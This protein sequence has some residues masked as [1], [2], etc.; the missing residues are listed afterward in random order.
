MGLPFFVDK[1]SGTTSIATPPVRQLRD[2]D[3]MWVFRSGSTTAPTVPSGWHLAPGGS[4][5]TCF[6]SLYYRWVDDLSAT[7]GTWT[8]ASLIIWATYRGVLGL[9]G[10]AAS[11]ATGT[12]VSIPAITM[13]QGAGSL[14]LVVGAAGHRTATALSAPTGMTVRA[15]Q[16]SAPIGAIWDTNGGVT[17]WSAQNSSAGAASSGHESI[18]IE[19]LGGSSTMDPFLKGTGFVL[20]NSNKTVTKTSGASA[21]AGL[22]GLPRAGVGKLIYRIDATHTD[23]SDMSPGLASSQAMALN[24]YTDYFS[25]GNSGNIFL[26]GSLVTTI[27][28]WEDGPNTVY[29]Y[30]DFDNAL[31]WG[32]VVGKNGW[33]GSG[34][35]NPATLTGGISLGTVPAFPCPAYANDQTDIGTLVWD[36]NATGNPSTTGTPWDTFSVATNI[37]IPQGALAFTGRQGKLDRGLTVPK[38]SLAIV[39]YVASLKTSTNRLIP[40]GSLALSGQALKMTQAFTLKPGQGSIATT[41]RAL[42][43]GLNYKLGS[44]AVLALTGYAPGRFVGLSRQLVAGSLSLTGRQAK[45]DMNLALKVK[46]LGISG[47]PM[48]LTG[49]DAIALHQGSLA[50]T[51]YPLSLHMNLGLKTGSLGLSGKTASLG[52]TII[53]GTASLGISGKKASLNNNL[54]L[55]VG[56]LAISGY[57]ASRGG[58]GAISPGTGNLSLVGYAPKVTIPI[59]LVLGVGIVGITG[60]QAKLDS[61]VKL[62]SGQIAVT[63]RQGK[64]DNGL[65]LKKGSLG[66]QGYAPKLSFGRVITPGVGTLGISSVR[67]KLADNFGL[68]TGHLSIQGQ[69]PTV[70]GQGG[71]QLQTGHIGIQGYAPTVTQTFIYKPANQNLAIQGYAPKVSIGTNIVIPTGHLSS[72][73]QSDHTDTNIHE[74]TAHLQI[75]GQPVTRIQDAKKVP[76]TRPLV[77]TGYPMKMNMGMHIPVCQL[78][79]TG[80]FLQRGGDFTIE[81]STGALV[82]TTYAPT[83]SIVATGRHPDPDYIGYCTPHTFEGD[84]YVS[85][86]TANIDGSAQI[87]HTRRRA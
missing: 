49:V 17:S 60:R 76:A 34:T 14:S 3:L 46:N 51:G 54:R 59:R 57:P 40:V 24:N 20:S 85:M 64:V 58:T 33:N 87:A 6:G 44:P 86:Q 56:V 84:V 61:N 15:T 16:G 43:L 48:T 63:G 38:A 4:G 55:G 25:W 73:G 69:P 68:K 12:S 77:I 27:D 22:M 35:A 2:I 65:A 62:L 81:T 45:T 28:I 67:G 79:I 66:V 39:G 36:G 18:T 32:L 50:I 42:S 7:S 11:N 82:L 29:L 71:I 5:N 31:F 19:L 80:R 83:I 47:Y 13:I 37:T 74:Q 53:P 78:G 8:S 23:L 10:S 75:T 30:F 9:G 72:S 21:V 70:N 41:G 1:A 26:N 52:K